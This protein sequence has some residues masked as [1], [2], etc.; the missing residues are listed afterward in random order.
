MKKI[1]IN[2]LS[3]YN[4][5]N[6][7]EFIFNYLVKIKDENKKLIKIVIHQT[8]NPLFWNDVSNKLNTNNI[9]TSLMGIGPDYMTKIFNSFKTDCEYSCS[10][11]DDILINNYL[12]DYIIENIDILSDDD[13]LFLAPLISN[14]IPS[15][16]YFIEQFFDV[17][18]KK[19]LNDI[20][21]STT[22]PQGLWGVDYNS[23]NKHTNS[24]EWIPNNF[25]DEVSKINHY[26]KGIHPIR[27]SYPAHLKL[28]H[29]IIKNFSK[30]EMNNNYELMSVKRPYFCNSFYFIK[31]KTWEKINYDKSLICD[32]FDEVPLNMYKDRHNL[33]MIFVKNGFCI[34]MAYNTIGSH[35]Q[36][37]IQDYYITEL[38]KLIN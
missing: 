35:L 18:E 31:T 22:I 3:H 29:L 20:F 17:D 9:E 27:V 16:D 26:Y 37:V 2:I 19:E 23:L 7:F 24:E 12:W 8:N 5:E 28:V 36:K 1:Q 13:N 30:F 25:Y 14:G 10:M 15:V 21:R 34:H 33:N 11:D 4:R 6:F 38:E 32:G